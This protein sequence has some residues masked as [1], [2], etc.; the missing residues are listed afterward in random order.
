MIGQMER[1]A[2][3]EDIVAKGQRLGQSPYGILI[4]ASL[5]EREAKTDEDRPKIAR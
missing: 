3:Q 5:I 2:N 1:V 4:I